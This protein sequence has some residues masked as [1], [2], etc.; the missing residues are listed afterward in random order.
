VNAQALE[1]RN[2]DVRI[3]YEVLGESGPF[4]LFVHG[5]AYSRRGWGPGPQLLADEFRVVLLD[6][7]GVG[8]SDAPPG[9]YSVPQMVGDAVTVLD[10]VGAARA[11]VVGVSLGGYIAQELAVTR[12][13][14]VEKLVLL[15]TAVA[16]GDGALPMPQR[17]IDGF[18]R[19]PQLSREEG[20]RL[21]VEN[22]LGD[23]AVRERPELVD[24]VYRYRL[25][26][27]PP[28]EAWQAQFAAGAGF[29]HTSRPIEEIQAPTL[30]LHGGADAIVDPRNAE[31]L[32]QRI[33]NARLE[34]IPDRGHL[35][36]WQEPEWF[37]ERLREFL[38]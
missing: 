9:P 6:N 18:T 5:L 10:A 11:H 15:S 37:A 22:S 16:A 24:E 38:R 7:R 32:A 31:L 25:E 26:H 29:L 23:H 4:V 33:P 21:L 14:R 30:V 28:L 13:E 17:G 36:M 12:P 35:A 3:A 19:F 20:L 34:T 2:G 8:E 27:A 1:A